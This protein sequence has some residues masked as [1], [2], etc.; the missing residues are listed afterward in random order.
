[1]FENKDIMRCYSG[2]LAY[3]T[4]LPTS[5][6]DIR[7][8]FCAPMRS[9][10]TPFFPIKELT[11]A[12]EED[13]K[14][15]ELTNFFKLFSEMNPNIIELAFVDESDIIQT[16]EAYQ[17]IRDVGYNLLS[18]KV[19]FSFSGYAMAQLKRIKGHD[20]WINNPQP[21]AQ[22]T[23]RDYLRLTHSWMDEKLLK[24]QD[25]QYVLDRLD[26]MSIFLPMGDNI[27]GVI[28][29]WDS[30]GLFNTDGSIRRVEYSALSDEDKKRQP[31]LIVKYLADEH[32]QAKEKHRNYWTWKENRNEV[33]HE[34]EVNYGYD[35]KHAMHLVRLMRMAEEILTTGEVK[36]KRPD[37][38]ELLD[39]RGG[40]WP[41]EDL[42]K[43]AE[44]KDEFIR[45]ELYQKSKLPHSFDRDYG[46]Q[47]LMEI[48]DLVWHN[49]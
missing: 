35:T 16:S 34:L 31:T 20:K 48:Q 32:K 29:S 33:R 7:G 39:I 43:W 15:Y 24:H 21:E 25:F 9:I 41:L 5:D 47:V 13:G 10:R 36:V 1:M 40:A 14:I 23:Q 42:L 22:P 12:D 38:K 28:G 37:A 46:A 19:A 26:K 4:N 18:K 27:F 44:E 6:V 8:L 2:S 17:M 11:L 30:P 3:G 45:G 49:R